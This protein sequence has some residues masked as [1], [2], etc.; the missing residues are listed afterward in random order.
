M[1]TLIVYGGKSCEHDISIITGCLAKGYFGGNVYC[2]YFSK[3]N[4]L[5]LV[6]NNFTPK[7]HLCFC[8]LPTVVFAN[9]QKQ[10]WVVKGR[11][12]TKKINIDVVV[13]CCHGKN[14][15]DGALKGLCQ[16]ANLPMVGSGLFASSICL[17]KV[18]CKR[19]LKSCRVPVVDG[20]AVTN[21]QRSV[22]LDYASKCWPVVV[23]PST[24]GSSI[25]ITLCSDAMQLKRALDV[26][27]SF[28]NVVL[29]ERG[30]ADFSEFNCSAMLADG[31]VQTSAIDSP[32]KGDE[33]LSFAD[34]YQR[35][36]KFQNP[37]PVVPK[38]LQNKIEMLAKRVYNC[39]R[40]SGVVRVD[41]LLDKSTN[42]L[43]V[44]EVNT[45]PGSLAYG[46]WQH[47]YTQQ[48]FGALL[49]RSAIQQSLNEQKLSTTFQSNVLTSSICKK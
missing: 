31:A 38:T 46:L 14:G 16:M 13:N 32:L 28:D 12:V 39:L 49:V 47:K 22:A 33:I 45:I 8:K 29:V 7:D 21:K 37:H 10:I 30:L 23:K 6:P 41:F 19:M 1:N 43:Y 25:G 36:E 4:D 18:L 42:K 24:L 15:E 44:N 2:A 40:C 3:N 17:D 5:F 20:I 11:I 9:G 27:F 26:A 35:G 34:K 48:Q